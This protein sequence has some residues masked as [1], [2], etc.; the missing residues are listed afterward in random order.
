M[1]A[2]TAPKGAVSLSTNEWTID[3]KEIQGKE[4]RKGVKPC[5][6][7]GKPGYYFHLKAC[8]SLK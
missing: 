1:Y 6:K 3:E 8:G 2:K 5:P 4:V 7:C